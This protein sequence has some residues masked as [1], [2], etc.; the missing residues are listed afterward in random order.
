MD[1][2]MLKRRANLPKIFWYQDDCKVVIRIMLVDIKEYFVEVDLDH[3]RFSTVHDERVHYLSLYFFGA[4]EP[5][6]T[7]NENT[8]RE[9][10]IQFVK[11]HKFFKWLRL[12]DT[13]QRIP[14]IIPDPDRIAE[15]SFNLISTVATWHNFEVYKIENR[16]NIYPD[17]PISDSDESDD[18]RYHLAADY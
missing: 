17:V 10:R 15:E 5:E 6:K 1:L 7:V 4:I 2:P 8:G 16:L 18:E 11:A 14:Q 3:V 13:A 9:I 12:E